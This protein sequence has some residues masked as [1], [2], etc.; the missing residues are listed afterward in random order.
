[1]NAWLHTYA[2]TGTN[3]Q[4]RGIFP[5]HLQPT[6]SAARPPTQ[7]SQQDCLW[8]GSMHRKSGSMDRELN[9]LSKATAVNL[10]GRHPEHTPLM[11]TC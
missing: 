3:V 11:R 1:M 5:S 8:G 2:G 4:P 10:T 7:Q 9:Q 6:A